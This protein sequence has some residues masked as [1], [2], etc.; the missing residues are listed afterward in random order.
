MTVDG[1]TTNSLT[2]GFICSKV[3][4]LPELLYGE[5]RL[6]HPLVR[7]GTK[8]TGSFERASWDEALELVAAQIRGA[9]DH[10][11]GESILPLSYGGSNGLLTQDTTDARLWRRLGAS[12][13]ARNVCAVPTTRAAAEMYGKMPG[14]AFHDYVEARLIIVWGCNPGATGIHVLPFIREAQARGARLVVVDPRRSK[15]ARSADLHL[16]VK[17]GTDVAVA[18]GLGN[19]L[20]ENG[21]ADSARLTATARVQ[22]TGPWQPRPTLPASLSMSCRLSRSGTRKRHRRSFVA[23]GG[24]SATATAVAQRPRSS[25]CQRLPVSSVFGVVATR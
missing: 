5:E 17:P 12:N 1:N 8:G 2:A 18:L 22:R 14:V 10:Y 16:A 7:T 21:H 9:R 15:L 4:A 24:S 20:F 23:D 3:R 25:R 6:R 13:L 11:G 19:W